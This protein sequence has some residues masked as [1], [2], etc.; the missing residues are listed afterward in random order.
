MIDSKETIVQKK[1]TVVPLLFVKT[2]TNIRSRKYVGG[3]YKP[4]VKLS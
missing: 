1:A 3:Y 4:I 2:I